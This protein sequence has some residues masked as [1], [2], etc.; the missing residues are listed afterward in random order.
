MVRRCSTYQSPTPSPNAEKHSYTITHTQNHS[1]P[2]NTI[3][4]SPPHQL[5]PTPHRIEHFGFFF[6]SPP[7]FFP[8]SVGWCFSSEKLENVASHVTGSLRTRYQRPWPRY[9]SVPSSSSSTAAAFSSPC[10]RIRISNRSIPVW[11]ASTPAAQPRD[12]WARLPTGR[13]STPGRSSGGIPSLSAPVGHSNSCS[14]VSATRAPNIRGV[15]M[16]PTTDSSVAV[17]Q[18]SLTTY[19]GRN[20]KYERKK[21]MLTFQKNQL[22]ELNLSTFVSTKKIILHSVLQIR[23]NCRNKFAEKFVLTVWWLLGH[24]TLKKIA[25]QVS[26]FK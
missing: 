11:T 1:Q 18:E 26:L 20:N 16:R 4:P 25:N 14:V 22:W 7:S 19:T 8:G 12:T 3:T 24:K 17:P 5:S 13:A 21:N 2:Q 15:T 6:F 9:E 10:W 23:L